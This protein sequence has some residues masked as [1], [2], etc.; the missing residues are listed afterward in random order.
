MLVNLLMINFETFVTPLSPFITICRF[1]LSHVF[2]KM[3]RW[4]AG[5]SRQ[6]VSNRW[7]RRERNQKA[8]GE[9]PR[10]AEQPARSGARAQPGS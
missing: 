7:P 6:Q 8:G 2:G 9:T 3:A 4:E 1:L 5:C 10:P